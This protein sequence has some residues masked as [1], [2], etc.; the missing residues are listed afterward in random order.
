MSES[1]PMAAISLT[2]HFLLIIYFCC[3]NRGVYL[4]GIITDGIRI[5]KITR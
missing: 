1:P 5:V 4:R 3:G 2:L